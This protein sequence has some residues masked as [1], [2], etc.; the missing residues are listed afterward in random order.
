MVMTLTLMAAANARIDGISEPGVQSPM[1]TRWRIC[2]FTCRYRGRGSAWEIV[3]ELCMSVYT[4]DTLDP[5][6]TERKGSAGPHQ[7]FYGIAPPP[8][9]RYT[10]GLPP[11]RARI[12]D[13][14]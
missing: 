1:A 3:N 14:K 9:R 10:R 6:D 4:V 11:P 5:V 7:G 12:P 8:R 2:S 13:R